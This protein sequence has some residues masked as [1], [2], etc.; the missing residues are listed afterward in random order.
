MP[1]ADVQGV[2]EGSSMRVIPDANPA[3]RKEDRSREMIMM[4]T[5]VGIEYEL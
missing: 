2:M 3:A 4:I 5:V 1:R